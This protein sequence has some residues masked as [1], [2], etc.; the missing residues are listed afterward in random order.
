MI[1]GF[2]LPFALA[3]IAIPLESFIHS[4][5]TILGLFAIAI[6]RTLHVLLRSSASVVTQLSKVIIS[7][8]DLIIMV[9]LSI[10]NVISKR[11]NK[12]TNKSSDKQEATTD[13]VSESA[14]ID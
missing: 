10:E 2:I 5:R 3:F 9:P 8:Y 11:A 4:L 12:S 7:L 13:L 1:M 6:L 14:H